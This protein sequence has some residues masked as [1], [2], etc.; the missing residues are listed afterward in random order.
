MKMREREKETEIK[1]RPSKMK[2]GIQK[3][4]VNLLYLQVATEFTFKAAVKNRYSTPSS[5]SS[6]PS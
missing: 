2:K 4:N 3:K 1:G 6:K 5:H